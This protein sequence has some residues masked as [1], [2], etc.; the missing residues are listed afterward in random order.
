MDHSAHRT[1]DR[2]AARPQRPL[3]SIAHFTRRHA[4]PLVGGI[5]D[6]RAMDRNDRRALAA[7]RG[8]RAQE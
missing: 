7:A 6:Q 5:A 3:G 1:I 2:A 8:L 4:A